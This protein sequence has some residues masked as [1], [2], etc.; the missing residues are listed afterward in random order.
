MKK[1]A[2]IIS[3]IVY[4][5]LLGILGMVSCSEAPLTP[6]QQEHL[7]RY[8]EVHHTGPVIVADISISYCEPSNGGKSGTGICDRSIILETP[9]HRVSNMGLCRTGQWPPVWHGMHADI[10]FRLR[11]DKIF[12]DAS[13]CAII[14][15]AVEERKENQ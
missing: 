14:K 5:L 11:Q 7:N 15:Y 10:Y 3:M 1:D 12:D 2:G 9:D 4:G 8:T 13:E 6:A